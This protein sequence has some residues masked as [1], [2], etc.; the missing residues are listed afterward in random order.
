MKIKL[1]L[2]LRVRN[3][4]LLLINGVSFIDSENKNTGLEMKCNLQNADNL[5]H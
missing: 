4:K 1:E 2:L 5:Y 3:K